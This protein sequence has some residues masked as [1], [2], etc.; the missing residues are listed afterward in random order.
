MTLVPEYH[1]Q[2]INVRV[3]NRLHVGPIPKREDQR[4]VAPLP[5]VQLET[6]LIPMEQ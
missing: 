5:L 3:V 6:R 1:G 2:A 4:R